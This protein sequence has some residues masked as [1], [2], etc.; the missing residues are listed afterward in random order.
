MNGHSPLMG[1]RI[2]ILFGSLEMGGAERQGLLL[3]AHL[4]RVERADVAVWGLGGGSA[5]GEQCD[6]LGIPWRS[7]PL[8]WGLRRRPVHLLRLGSA[9]R[10]A[11]PD[12]LLPYTR[13]PN[14]AAAL[15]WR[16]GRA[17]LCV[18]NQADA[19]LLLPPTLLHRFAVSRVRHFIANAAEGRHFLLD[20]FKLPPAVVRLIENGVALA[21]P[22]ADRAVWRQRLT[23][24]ESAPVTVMVANLSR[25]KD[26]ATLLAAWQLL[27]PAA[28]DAVLV[29][30]G[31][32]D[33][34]AGVLQRQAEELGIS[35]R[36]RFSGSVD[37]VSGLLAAADLCA[38]SSRSEGIPNAVLEAM[39]CGL[40]V[41]GSDIPGLRE[42]VGD[43]GL[44]FLA[45]PGDPVALAE[46]L[47][48]LLTNPELRRYQG[49]LMR[50]RVQQRF[51]AERICRETVAYLAQA[52]EE[53]P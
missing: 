28:A 51:S 30:A 15:L 12:I 44:A 32:L 29:L 22:E 21:P 36:V 43:E 52:L 7:L 50:Q 23:I 42:A 47:A 20:T 48:R 37:D 27:P 39:A 41:A 25:Y 19:G 33:D 40:A 35:Q 3:A 13:V 4:H 38:H 31:R 53:T 46:R 17:R 16:L 24:A 8:H 10:Q 26:H 45:P 6:R 5:V 34:Q 18:W 14:L 9:L 2:I 1:R 49:D 11:R